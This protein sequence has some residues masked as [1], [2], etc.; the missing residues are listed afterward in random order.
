MLKHERNSPLTHERLTEMLNYDPET[1]LF[2]WRVRAS[3]RVKVGTVCNNKDGHGYVRVRIDTVSY[4]AA[5]LAWFYVHKRWP[6]NDIDHINGVKD[7]NRIV[8]LREATRSQ[9]LANRRTLRNGLKGVCYDKKNGRWIAQVSANKQ[10]VFRQLFDTEEEA[11]RA[12]LK[13]AK[14]HHGE[15]ARAS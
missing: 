8:N 6:T 10:I 9:N 3:N 15:F 1:G 11:H 13:A 4:W 2:S 5:R 7:D 14:L 12:Y